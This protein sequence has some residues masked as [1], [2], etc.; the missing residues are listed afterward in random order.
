MGP[1]LKDSLTEHLTKVYSKLQ[2]YN[3]PGASS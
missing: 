1:L 2:L 3:L